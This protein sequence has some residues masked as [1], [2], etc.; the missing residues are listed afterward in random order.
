MA[1]NP[2]AELVQKLQQGAVRQAGADNAVSK[3]TTAN[4]KPEDILTDI[5]TQAATPEGLIWG[6]PIIEGVKPA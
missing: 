5:L 2:K 6:T 1:V 4:A 3:Q